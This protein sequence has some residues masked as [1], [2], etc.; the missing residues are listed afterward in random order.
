MFGVLSRLVKLGSGYIFS[1]V[2]TD[3]VF[4]TGVFYFLWVLIK[5]LYGRRKSALKLQEIAGSPQKHWFYGH[6]L[7]VSCPYW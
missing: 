6:L 3:I 5:P 2:I 1:T 7:Q 4:F